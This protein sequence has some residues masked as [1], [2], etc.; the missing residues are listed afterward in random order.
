MVDFYSEVPLALLANLDAILLA[1]AASIGQRTH[2]GEAVVARALLLAGIAQSIVN[3]SAPISGTEHVTSHVLDM[4]AEASGRGLALHG[5]QVGIA[6]LTAA[7][8]YQRFLDEFDPF[9]IDIASCYPEAAP[10]RDHITHLFSAIDGSGAM[11]EECWHDYRKKL[12]LWRQNRPT[13]EQFCTQWQSI[14]RPKLMSLVCAPQVVHRILSQVGAPLESEV[15]QPPIP[16]QEYDFAVH[17]GHFIR[18]RFV[19]GDLLY[20]LGWYV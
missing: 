15:L 18:Q 6:T 8:L 20:F 11:A 17:N 7:H 3:M 19:L 1:Y 12:A 2:E 13:F 16:R 5:A 10:L 14:H 9:T 4:I